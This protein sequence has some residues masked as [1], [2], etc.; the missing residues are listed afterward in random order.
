MIG[1]VVWLKCP[2]PWHR[3]G[4]GNVEGGRNTTVDDARNFCSLDRSAPIETLLHKLLF[5]LLAR[6]PGQRSGL[7]L[8]LQLGLLARLGLL[9]L[10]VLALLGLVL[11]LALLL[12]LSMLFLSS[13]GAVATLA[14]PQSDDDSHVRISGTA[15]ARLSL[16]RIQNQIDT[17]PLPVVQYRRCNLLQNSLRTRTTVLRSAM[18]QCEDPINR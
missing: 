16:W 4:A 1:T 11:L 12:V 6:R 5:F 8:L 13:Y 2:H 18:E 9:E 10:L 7:P 3:L 14:A 17:L 15:T